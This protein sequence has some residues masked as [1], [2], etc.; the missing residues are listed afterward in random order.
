VRKLDCVSIGFTSN[1]G[2][3]MDARSF[4]KGIRFAAIWYTN[5]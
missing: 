4:A 1:R 5:R 2:M 3:A